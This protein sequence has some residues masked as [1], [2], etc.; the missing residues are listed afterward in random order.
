MQIFGANTIDEDEAVIE[1]S[2]I[3]ERN[4]SC[5]NFPVQ[6]RPPMYSGGSWNGWHCKKSLKVH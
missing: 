5:Q 1:N 2:S 3:E 6:P 4:E